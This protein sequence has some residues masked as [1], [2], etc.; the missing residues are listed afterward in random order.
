MLAQRGASAQ[1]APCFNTTQTIKTTQKSTWLHVLFSFACYLKVALH[2]KLCFPQPTKNPPGFM[3]FFHL[4]TSQNIKNPP[5]LKVR[6][7][8]VLSKLI[9]NLP[10]H[11]SLFQLITSQNIKNP[12][13]LSSKCC[14]AFLVRS[15][16]RWQ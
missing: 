8:F 6:S 14:F 13:H 16:L 7:S 1:A 3:C 5:E 11:M 4:L 12:P 10:Q 9:K 2:L 15:S